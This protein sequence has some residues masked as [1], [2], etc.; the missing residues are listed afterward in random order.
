MH[1]LRAFAARDD[2]TAPLLPWRR[3]VWVARPHHARPESPHHLRV[4]GGEN[5]LGAEN[6]TTSSVPGHPSEDEGEGDDGHVAG[7]GREL[8]PLAR[9][10]AVLDYH[11]ELS[12]LLLATESEAET[13]PSSLSAAAAS[14]AMRPRT[15]AK[16]AVAAHY[17][18]SPRSLETWVR[19][20]VRGESLHNR[21]GRGR[22]SVLTA[23]VKRAIVDARNGNGGRSNRATTSAVS[24]LAREETGM[25]STRY[26]ER[27]LTAPSASTVRAVLGE[28]KLVA[29]RKRPLLTSDNRARRAAYAREE[30]SKPWSERVERLV[31]LDECVLSTGQ[32]GNGTIV[33]HPDAPSSASEQVRNRVVRHK[34]HVSSIMVLGVVALPTMVGAQSL[35]DGAL[36]GGGGDRAST[37]PGT[38][39]FD[40]VRNGKVALLR[41]CRVDRYRRT[42]YRTEYDFVTGKRR[43]VIGVDGAPVVMHAKGD[44]RVASRTLDGAEYVDMLTRPDGVLDRVER[45]FGPGHAEVTVVQDGAP[46]H[47]FDNR[48]GGRTTVHQRAA[49]D[50]AARRGVKLVKQPPNSPDMSVLDLGVWWA[51]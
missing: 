27:R 41:V 16:N 30:L 6:R 3:R 51:L 8:H 46:A 25:W 4:L 36:E 19:R 38:A 18:V 37:A 48:H 1:Q 42:V 7:L 34:T 43:K 50:A 49:V 22:R 33:V 45:Y 13:S 31:M 40:P 23:D 28:G 24:A 29:V 9:A 47:G 17:R 15:R 21:A 32:Q 14:R 39:T 44:P 20:A 5:G 10:Q 26:R 35:A 2:E 12:R 11:V